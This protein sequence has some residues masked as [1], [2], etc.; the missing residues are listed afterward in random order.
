MKKWFLVLFA[1]PVMVAACKKGSKNECTS[2]FTTAVAVP[3]EKDSLSRYISANSIAAIADTSGVY[4]SVDSAGTGAMPGICSIMTLKYSAYLLGNP[5]PFD[6]Y[7]APGGTSFSLGSLIAGWQKVLPGI[8][9][10]SKVTLYVPPSLAYG[11]VDKR[12]G[13][14]EV[15]IPGNSYLKFNIELINVQ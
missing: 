5:I 9:S 12:D 13:N 3:A 14:G 2:T 8:K 6:S 10:G 4:F 11:A 7:T 1:V 15:V